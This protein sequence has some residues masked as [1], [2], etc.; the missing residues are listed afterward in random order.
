[1]ILSAPPRSAPNVGGLVGGTLLGF[2]LVVAGLLTA[3]LTAATPLVS[4]LVPGASSGGRVTIGL[5]VWSFAMIAGGAML[6]AGTSRLAIMLAALRRGSAHR[7][8]AAHAL[9]SMRDEVV[10]A[11]RVVVYE[12]RRI[13][14]LAIGAFGVA[15]V[16][17][18]PASRQIRRSHVGWESRTNDVWRPMDDPLDA[19]TRDA[20]LVRR[21]LSTADLDFVVRVY[22]ALVVSDQTI[23]RSPTC[24]VITAEQIPAWVASLPHQRTLTAGRRGRLLGMA[25]STRT[26][27]ADSRK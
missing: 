25:R 21:W 17:S 6:A 10:V 1:M 7:G 8:P 2:L 22:A 14:E 27:A 11:D 4:S 23:Q 3:Y 12:G 26:P 5:G 18:L 19:A 9:A 15:V 24:A 13:P 20:D 16:H